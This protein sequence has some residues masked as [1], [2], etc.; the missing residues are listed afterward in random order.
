MTRRVKLVTLSATDFFARQ[1]SPLMLCD[2][3][4]YSRYKFGVIMKMNPSTKESA[5]K[6]NADPIFLSSPPSF[7][8]KS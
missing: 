3:P 1:N 6:A 2:L 8:R 4:K 5:M 7:W